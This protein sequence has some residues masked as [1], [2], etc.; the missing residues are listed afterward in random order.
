MGY[1]S[2]YHKSTYIGG[3]P[4]SDSLLGVR[5]ILAD[6][7][8]IDPEKTENID[9]EIENTKE[10]LNRY[11]KL[12][13]SD[14]N[15]NA[16]YNPYAL[17]I[18]FGVSSS[19]LDYSFINKDGKDVNA[20][21]YRNLNEMVSAMLGEETMLEIFKDVGF[22]ST[23]TSNCNSTHI[24]GHYKYVHKD[25]DSSA[26]ITYKF[27]ADRNGDV[28][29]HM[30]SDYQRQPDI[31]LNGDD[32]GSFYIDDTPRGFY[33]GYFEKGDEIKV[34]ITLKSDVLYIKNGEPLLY[35][36]DE[37]VFKA[38]FDRLSKTQ[39]VINPEYKEDHISGSIETT[40]EDQLIMTTIPYDEGWK[41]LVD[42][43]EVEIKKT[44]DAFISFD[45][46]EIGEHSIEFIYRSDAFVYGSIC[47]LVFICIF[48]LL[49]IF[50][51]KI[52]VLFHGHK[53]TEIIERSEKITEEAEN[54]TDNITDG[55]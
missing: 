50:E 52:T 8:I 3:N 12:Y 40:V 1:F 41:V 20:D 18:A 45:I 51:K 10:L 55:D 54:T 2:A 22:V 44:L 21:P 46:S 19:V 53:T 43:K 36:F 4:V 28:Y 15:Y 24:E 11:Y 31:S 14:D 39:M 38:C 23:S 5:Y 49:V 13:R 32:Y 42:G 6:N 29:F 34:K 17:S 9:F 16:Y 7:I 30:P 35:Y 25:I 37:D 26:S 27:K 48:V 47:S 33:L